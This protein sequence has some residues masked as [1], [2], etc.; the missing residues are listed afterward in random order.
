MT[1]RF[2]ILQAQYRSTID[3][4]NEALL[5]SEKGLERLLAATNALDSLPVSTVSSVDFSTLKEKC[6]D[7][8]NDDLNS[9]VAIAHL[10]D[11]VKII[12]SIKS[13][14]EKISTVDLNELKSFFHTF[15]FD[16]L[17]LQPEKTENEGDLSML[18]VVVDLMLNLRLEAKARKNWETADKI[19]DELNKIGIEIKDSKEGFEWSL[20]GKPEVRDMITD[21]EN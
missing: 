20:R 5:A 2:F 12:N 10:F 13:G 15:V 11:G 19:R 1:I 3:F 9:P 17:G 8:L 7:A 6:F 21:D 16:I 14:K 18:N 4:S